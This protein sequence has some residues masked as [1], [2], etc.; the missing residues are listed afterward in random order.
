MAKLAGPDNA[1]FSVGVNYWPRRSAT[2]MWRFFDAGE[3]REDFARIVELGLDAVRL[4][5]RWDE[6]Q[7]QP[8]A[9]D[10]QML[11]RL[12]TIVTLA[13]ETG[14]RALP[15][16]CGTLNG[17]PFMPAWSRD[18]DDLYRGKLLAAQLVLARA[19]G[20]RLRGHPAIVAW[21]IGHAFTA[22]RPPRSGKLST[23]DHGSVP[24]AE[25]D[26]A[27][28]SKR[29]AGDLKPA[30]IAATAGTY[31]VDITTDTN[32]RLGSLCAPLAFA[33]M[34]GSSVT[35]A[36]ARNRLDPE[37]LPFLAMVTA[38]FSYKPV[39]VTAFGNPTCP[40][41]KFS[42]YERFAQPGEPPHWTI[43]P[44]DKT[45]A[46]YPCLSEDENAAYASAVLERLHADGRLGAY[47]W[48]WSDYDDEVLVGTHERTYGIIRRDGSEKPVARALAA[49]ARERRTVVKPVE[50]PM[51]SSTYYYRTLPVS[52]R[53]LY[54]AFLS[55]VEERRAAVL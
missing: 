5:V 43:S 49:F 39:L 14:L 22:I 4:F 31:S 46:T 7:P 48:C 25:R 51:I 45:F 28:W 42:P 35:A 53:T 3:I 29:I 54:D 55:F 47:W 15:S 26:V 19:I 2:A 16:L 6:V 13:A 10:A 34:Q 38:A 40:A 33:S 12:E 36:F 17:T 23:G 37:V 50:M 21:D 20:G 18:L 9:V 52:T 24:V 41:G 8:D 11:D 44:D 30:S 27:E 32:I 1:R